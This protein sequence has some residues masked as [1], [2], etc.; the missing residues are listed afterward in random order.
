ML[1][2]FRAPHF[3]SYA[4]KSH[5][6]LYLPPSPTYAGLHSVTSWFPISVADPSNGVPTTLLSSLIFQA[7]YFCTKD[8]IPDVCS[9]FSISQFHPPFPWTTLKHFL[10]FLGSLL[11]NTA[12]FKAA[13]T[14]TKL[15]AVLNLEGRT[16]HVSWHCVGA[17]SRAELQ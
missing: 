9:V 6:H 12:H 15:F 10:S 13:S 4:G 5:Y 17:T 3:P 16:Q 14:S 8:F 11:S 7:E 2:P 1:R